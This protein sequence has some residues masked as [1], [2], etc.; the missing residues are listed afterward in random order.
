M[1]TTTLKLV[2]YIG[3]LTFISCEQDDFTPVKYNKNRFEEGTIHLYAR[4]GEINDIEK[5]NHFIANFES[6]FAAFNIVP[7]LDSNFVEYDSVDFDFEIVSSSK[8]RFTLSNGDVKEYGIIRK[9]GTILFVKDS[10]EQTPI[11]AD[12]EWLKFQPVI[13]KTEPVFGGQVTYFKPT[14]YAYEVDGEIQFPILSLMVSYNRGMGYLFQQREPNSISDE[15]LAKISQP[16]GPTDTIIFRES[17]IV[18]SKQ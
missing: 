11:F 14:I 8:A 5:A 13:V 16:N 2:L 17:R 18:F 4:G 1:K 12:Y 15:Y 3:F 10:T 9:N 7:S 6:A